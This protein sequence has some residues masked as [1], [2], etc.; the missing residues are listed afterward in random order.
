[1]AGAAAVSPVALEQRHRQVDPDATVLT[2]YTS[3][4]Q[5]DSPKA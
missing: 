2:M 3:G 4:H 1:M 5:R